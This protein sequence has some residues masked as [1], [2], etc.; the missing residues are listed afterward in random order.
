EE[1]GIEFRLTTN[2]RARIAESDRL[3]AEGDLDGFPATV[4]QHGPLPGRPADWRNGERTKRRHR[5]VRS[6]DAARHDPQGGLRYILPFRAGVYYVVGPGGIM[7]CVIP[8][9]PAAEEADAIVGVG[10]AA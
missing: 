1:P 6:A 2:R 7:P 8:P 4:L 9:R 3:P 10:S 5:L